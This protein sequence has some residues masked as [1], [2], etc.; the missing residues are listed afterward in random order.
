MEKFFENPGLLHIGENILK[1]LPF[2]DKVICRLVR[3]SWKI[4][5]D[6]L[7]SK[8]GLNDLLQM[9]QKECQI[10]KSNQI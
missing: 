3:K 7:A 6:N 9:L 5:L 2:E 10:L 8:V 1:N 4:I